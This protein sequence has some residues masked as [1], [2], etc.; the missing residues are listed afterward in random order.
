MPR[1][2]V[3]L[4]TG[5]RLT[6]AADSPEQA[7]TIAITRNYGRLAYPVRTSGGHGLAGWFR[8]YRHLSRG[9]KGSCG[10]AIYVSAERSS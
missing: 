3:Q 9:R 1:F 7:A 6:V 4:A 5:A 2:A 10:A 8:P